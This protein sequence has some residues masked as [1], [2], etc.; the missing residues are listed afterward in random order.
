MRLVEEDPSGAMRIKAWIAELRRLGRESPV[1]RSVQRLVHPGHQP[2]RGNGLLA[3][4]PL[5]SYQ[6]PGEEPKGVVLLHYLHGDRDQRSV[7]PHAEDAMLGALL[8]L[9]A[10]RRCEVVPELV[11]KVEG[12]D[13]SLLIP[14]TSQAD[15]KLAAP[16][17]PWEEI[18]DGLKEF[19]SRFA[20]L[21]NGDA[22]TLSAAMPMHYCAV[23][24]LPRDVTG[25]YAIAVSGL[26]TL[27]HRFGTPPTDWNSWDQSQRWERFI[28]EHGLTQDQAI[29]LRGRLMED[30]SIRLA[31]T[32]RSYV[33]DRLPSTFWTEPVAGY[34]WGVNA[35]SGQAIEG[36]W[37]EPRPRAPRFA[38][39]PDALRNALKRAYSARSSY[40]HA[41]ERPVPFASHLFA[42]QADELSA[43][44][45]VGHLRAALQTLILLEMRERTGCDDDFLEHIQFI[46]D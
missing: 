22:E 24:L 11:A 43:T 45:S 38:E 32:F 19:L 16:L 12:N 21:N 15:S 20:V 23:L 46:L 1:N 29:A 36:S 42:G 7:D 33:G 13:R 4:Q 17:P 31:E 14:L 9:V 26:E 37:S 40:L 18:N 6:P 25:A 39:D 3:A 10:D 44:L 27:A 34:T 5:R 35:S 8:T 28:D 41:G 2:T 30:R